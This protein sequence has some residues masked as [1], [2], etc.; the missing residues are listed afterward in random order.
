MAARTGGDVWSFFPGI[1]G[2]APAIPEAFLVS[3]AREAM[4]QRRPKADKTIS[5]ID[6]GTPT[7]HGD[8]VRSSFT[9]DGAGRVYW[10]SPTEERFILEIAAD[11]STS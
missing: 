9:V 1:D 3:A 11:A 10:S 7:P 6:Y 2:S 4:A 5:F 8:V